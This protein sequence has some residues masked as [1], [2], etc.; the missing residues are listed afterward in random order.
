MPVRRVDEANCPL[1]TLLA[2]GDSED[3]KQTLGHTDF[4]HIRETHDEV[5]RD[6]CF[7]K[8]ATNQQ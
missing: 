7:V 4:I 1:V 2:V 6:F 3:M 8:H 5:N